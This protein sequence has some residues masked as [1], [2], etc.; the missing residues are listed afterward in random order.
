MMKK[1]WHQIFV[2]KKNSSIDF[3]STLILTYEENL[4]EFQNIHK[5][6]N[7]IFLPNQT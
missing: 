5:Y 2:E 7:N 4:L 6:N 3:I 1:F